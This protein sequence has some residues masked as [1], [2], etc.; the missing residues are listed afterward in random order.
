MQRNKRIQRF[1]KF[2]TVLE[3]TGRHKI[4]NLNIDFNEKRRKK[5]RFI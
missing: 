1:I 3:T 4:A 5:K 2:I